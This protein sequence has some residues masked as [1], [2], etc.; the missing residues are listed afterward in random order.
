MNT[1]GTFLTKLG[2]TTLGTT[3]LATAS[4]LVVAAAAGARM[5]RFGHWTST[6]S[7]HH[8]FAV[9]FAELVA[10]KTHGALG[11]A[12]YPNEQ[13]GTY[14]QQVDA[15]RAG[16]LDFSLPTSA[17]LARVDPRILILT[18]PYLF[19]STA[20]AYAVLDGPTGRHFLRG[21]PGSGIRV[22]A[23]STNGMRNITNSKRPIDSLNDLT[24][25]RVRVPPN[26]LS[27]ALFRSLGAQPIALPFGQVYAALRTGRADGQENPFVNIYTGKFYEVQRYLALTR[28]QFEGLGIVVSEKTWATFDARTQTAVSEAALEAAVY[29]RAEFDRVDATSRIKLAGLGMQIT[30][31]E[32]PPFEA[33][34]RALYRQLA[35][36]FGADLVHDVE[37]AARG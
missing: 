26:G 31:P 21:L 17:A 29:H 37:R 34:S 2:A 9:R 28:H 23:M 30:S 18:L 16:T 36:V 19:R 5:L 1:R 32:L 20:N 27:V 33:K 3:L 25:L 8:A 10:H 24:G 14:N 4:P 12:V 6:N 35:T 22:L 13:L 15:Q 7:P 11:I